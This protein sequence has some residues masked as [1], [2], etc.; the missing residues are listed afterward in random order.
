MDGYGSN[1]PDVVAR[2]RDL[3]RFPETGFLEYRTAALTAETLHGLGYTVRVGPEVM[4]ADAIAGRPTAAQVQAGQQLLRGRARALGRRALPR[5][6]QQQNVRASA[7][8][9]R[10]LDAYDHTLQLHSLQ[11]ADVQKFNTQ[12][13][14]AFFF[15]FFA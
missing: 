10:A 5:A 3:H 9:T 8:A 2:R 6:I 12:H 14:A 11:S 4:R 15:F 13:A 1:L 7:L